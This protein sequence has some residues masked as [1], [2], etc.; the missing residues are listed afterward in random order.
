[1]KT[2][3]TVYEA[4][5]EPVPIILSV[6][7]CGT[8]FPKELKNHYKPRLQQ[9]LDDTDWYVHRLYK[10]TRKMG[11]T[12]IRARYSR[13]VIDLNRDPESVPL[14]NDGRLITGLTPAT[15]F[16]GNN[17]YRKKEYIP[18][19]AETSR[20][21][22]AYYWPYYKKLEALLTERKAKFGNVLLWDAHSIR[23]F[24][25]T[26]RKGRFPDMIL[27]NKDEKTAHPHIIKTALQGLSSGEYEVNHND[28]F[29]GGHIT[30]YFGK[31]Q[32]NVHVLQLEMNKV[33]YMDDR[34]L[35]YNKAR[36]GEMRKVLKRTLK[37]VTKTLLAL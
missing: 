32:H 10:F 15:D 26:I 27:G 24:V 36:A 14:Y 23:T 34:E 5:G 29:K 22:E 28:P 13:W 6:P 11:I 9:Q 4:D 35:C 31:P 7:H 30:R 21:L 3:Y 2:P 18:D 1:M 19:A 25:P 37:E 20:R 33:L 12:M 8:K 16:F 17:I